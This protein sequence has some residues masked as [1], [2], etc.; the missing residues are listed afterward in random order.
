MVKPV[1]LIILDGWGVAPDSPGNAIARAHTP[2]WDKVSILYPHTSLLASGESV[3]LPSGEA[4]NSEV[5]HLNI[6]AG[7]VVY[8]ELPRV[9]MAISDG[10][11]LN[12]KALLTAAG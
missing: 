6:G 12:N 8:Q 11:F 1:V 5:G 4:G 10:S 9:N 7:M 3:G 2:F